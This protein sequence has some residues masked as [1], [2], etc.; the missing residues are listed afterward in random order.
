MTDTVS[1]K[2]HHVESKHWGSFL[3]SVFLA[4]IL[5][6]GPLILGGFRIWLVLPILTAI[7]LLV[8]FQAVRLFWHGN[9]TPG[10]FI[11]AVD[12]FAILFLVYA[13]VRYFTT[14]AEYVAR[15]EVM[16]IYAYAAVFWI[17]RYGFSRKTHALYLL[18]ALAVVGLIVTGTGY[19][20]HARPE[21]RPFSQDLLKGYAPRF[22]GTYG[23]P[24][25]FGALVVMTL[26]IV[27]SF[28]I[29]RRGN[30]TLRVILFYLA[31]MMVIAVGL[32]LSRG[33][34]LGLG[35][36][37]LVLSIFLIR[38]GY[39]R[40]YWLAGGILAFLLCIG[41]FFFEST[42]AQA[43]VQ[44]TVQI[45]QPGNFDSYVRIILARD[46]LKIWHDYPLFGTGPA[47]FLFMHLRYHDSQYSTLAQYTHDDYL[48]LLA[49][50]G[51]VGFLLALGFIVSVTRQLFR[52]L[53]PLPDSDEAFLLASSLCAWCALLIHSTFDF[54]LHIPANALILFA[55]TGIGLRRSAAQPGSFPGWLT[56]ANFTRPL[57]VIIALIAVGLLLATAYTARGYYP[58]FIAQVRYNAH[59][60][61]EAFSAAQE[62][63]EADPYSPQALKYLGDLYRSA[64]AAE[65]DLTLRTPIAQKAADAYARAVP[66][67]KLDDELLALQGLSY[68]FAGRH[69]EANLI[70][71]IVI[72]RQPYNGYFRLLLGLHYWRRNMLPEAQR[73][74]QEGA[75]CPH[76][77]EDNRKALEEINRIIGP[78]PVATPAAPPAEHEPTVP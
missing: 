23:C 48:N 14:P 46:S 47:T 63:V 65:A 34:W 50:Y 56:K 52:H 78:P 25:H 51:L 57:G 1:V 64:A 32:S 61:L 30:W 28:A 62:S 53:G 43:R 4:S 60:V 70:H 16:E 69:A 39:I 66:L 26:G 19:L 5:S 45:F 58:W 29:L 42:T 49:D 59:P 77:Y 35:A 71:Q 76:G 41:A 21:L 38:H 7:W 55:M 3:T 73:A 20:F 9:D 10:R 75:S 37:L 68:D 8:I 18:G 12:L 40:W 36:S 72:K 74:F 11:D 2:H 54:N 15:L 22:C 31:G 6:F 13:T 17:C 67:N 27:L 33:S 44:E 24:N